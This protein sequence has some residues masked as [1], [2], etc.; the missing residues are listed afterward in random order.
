M[1]KTTIPAGGLASDSVTTAKIVDDAV[2]AAK[3]SF[4]A[5]KI[6]QV[7]SARFT[8]GATSITSTTQ[9]ATEITDAITPS[10]SSSTIL[11]FVNAACQVYEGSGTGGK[12]Q[13]AIYRDINNSGSYSKIFA[14][15][16]NAYGGIG[17]F[18][19]GTELSTSVP[20]TMA[21]VDSPNTTS[22]VDYKLYL[23]LNVS[24]AQGDNVSTAAS[25]NERSIVLM[26]IAG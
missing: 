25:E 14:G 20:L 21:F 13:A 17:G 24:S 6:L 12:F 18:D 26:E 9:S 19:S 4:S 1:S 22:E 11:V 3:A 15:Q 7:Q 2:T 10:S 5:G 23:A 16:S 8:S